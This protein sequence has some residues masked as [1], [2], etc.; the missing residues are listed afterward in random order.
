ME[1]ENAKEIIDYER[2]IA[3]FGK[4]R[5]DTALQF[6]MLGANGYGDT[7]KMEK[8]KNASRKIWDENDK[9]KEQI[10]W[11]KPSE[12]L[13]ADSK[14]V[15]FKLQGDDIRMGRFY[16]NDQWDR[17]NMFCDGSFHQ[18]ENVIGWF[19]VPNCA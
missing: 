10:E 13:P 19:Y 7:E 4:E 6:F 2:Q 15:I 11:K 12:K 14:R 8:I 5:A 16:I 9:L 3:M 1:A 17:K 18:A